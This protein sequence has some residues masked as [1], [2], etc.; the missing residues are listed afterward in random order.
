MAAA[1]H[2]RVCVEALQ[3]DGKLPSGEA[4]RLAMKEIM[5]GAADAGTVGVDWLI[6]G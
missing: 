2:L 3:K 6:V 1:R 4:T 5:S